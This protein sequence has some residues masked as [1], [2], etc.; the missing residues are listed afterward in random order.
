MSLGEK[1]RAARKA[2]RKTQD[3]V[4]DELDVT[5]GA[6]SQWENDTTV[7]ELE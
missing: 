3:Q 1:M 4:A 2:A 6:V 7:P 5:K